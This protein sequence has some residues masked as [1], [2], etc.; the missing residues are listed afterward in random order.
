M[1]RSDLEFLKVAEDY[2]RDNPKSTTY[3][4]EE[5]EYI[6]LYFKESGSILVYELGL[7]IGFFENWIEHSVDELEYNRDE[8]EFKQSEIYKALMG[9]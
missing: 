8:F 2:F 5:A 7:E 6:A 9:Y 4:D 3:R 1:R